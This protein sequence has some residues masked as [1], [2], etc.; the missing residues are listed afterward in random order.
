M[1]R[2][3]LTGGY[4][5]GKSYVAGEFERL[6]AK[7]IYAD[8]LGHEVLLPS[9]DG[10]GPA[11]H[12]FGP[13]I[14][15]SDRLIDRKKLAARVFGNPEQLKQLSDIVHPGVRRLEAKLVAGY[16]EADPRAII[17]TE[18]AILI[19]TGRYKEFD[20]L[21]VTVCSLETQILRGIKR[22]Q[23]SRAEV[24]ERIGRQMPSDQKQAYAHYVV[25]TDGPKNTT[26]ERVQEIFADLGK[27]ASNT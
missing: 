1:L 23:L 16:R 8:V 25:S 21:I 9:G 6:G 27:L 18:A 13:G 4:A 26:A 22:D 10:Y 11:L 3:G 24:L 15:N 19:E 20:R 2:V 7:V 5:T 12:L 17:V 14:L